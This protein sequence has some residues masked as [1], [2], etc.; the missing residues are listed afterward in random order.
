M[1]HLTVFLITADP[2]VILATINPDFLALTVGELFMSIPK[3]LISAMSTFVVGSAVIFGD[4]LWH[5]ISFEP[6]QE[7][8]PKAGQSAPSVHLFAPLAF[9][10]K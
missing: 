8:T 7:A 1:D 10:S 9:H 5:K 2:D 6:S 4:F 3:N